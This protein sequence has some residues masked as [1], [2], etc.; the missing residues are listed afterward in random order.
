MYDN[1]DLQY[2][3]PVRVRAYNRSNITL[4]SA[5]DLYFIKTNGYYFRNKGLQRYPTSERCS[6][7]S[8]NFHRGIYFQNSGVKSSAR[9]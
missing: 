5:I 6:T 1:G 7:I 2:Y 8:I 9:T 4:S 3:Y